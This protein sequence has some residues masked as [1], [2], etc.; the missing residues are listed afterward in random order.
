MYVNQN[1]LFTNQIDAQC[2][3]LA[4]GHSWFSFTRSAM[5]SVTQQQPNVGAH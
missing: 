1:H 2:H 5:D 4:T 3:S